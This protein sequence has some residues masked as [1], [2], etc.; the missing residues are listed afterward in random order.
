[1]ASRCGYGALVARLPYS[2]SSLEAGCRGLSRFKSAASTAKLSDAHRSRKN[3]QEFGCFLIE[4]KKCLRCDVC[5][6]E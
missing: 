6:C 5:L 4:F 2:D 3:Y 1:M